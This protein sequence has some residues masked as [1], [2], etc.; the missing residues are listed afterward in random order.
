[1]TSPAIRRLMEIRPIYP[2]MPRGLPM[3]RHQLLIAL[4][5]VA[6]ATLVS[7]GLA[8]NV[9]AKE[10]KQCNRGHPCPT[11]TPTPTDGPTPTDVP[12]PTVTPTPTPTD[13]PISG[14]PVLTAAG[15][16]A[17]PIPSDATIATA[18]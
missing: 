18:N 13:G 10:P 12:S 1:M 3:R 14:D 6:A 5:L 11:P 7:G 2:R 9:E 17:D 4:S 8:P 15:D 16:I